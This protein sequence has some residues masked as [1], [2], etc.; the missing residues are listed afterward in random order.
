VLA[1]HVPDEHR[2]LF[3]ELDLSA[4]QKCASP[5]DAEFIL[6]SMVE[7]YLCRYLIFDSK[8]Q[9]FLAMDRRA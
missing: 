3:Q 1:L 8:W 9:T 6:T 4:K 5:K 7:S 2:L